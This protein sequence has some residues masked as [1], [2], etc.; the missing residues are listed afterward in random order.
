MKKKS[1]FPSPP[2]VLTLFFIA[3]FVPAC[4]LTLRQSTA[5]PSAASLTDPQPLTCVV[6]DPGHG[7]EDGGAVSASGLSEKEVNLAVALFLRD[8]LELNGI[9]VVM[10]REEDVLLYDPTADHQGRKKVLD[11]LSRKTIGA[12]CAN[13]LLVSIHMN[14]F[15]QPQY[16]GTQVW[17]GQKDPRSQE[18]AHSIQQSAL[19]L[20]PDNHR[21]IKTAGSGIYLLDQLTTPCVLVECGF[22]SNPEEAERLED[23][24]YQKALA[25]MIFG[26]IAPYLT[27]RTVP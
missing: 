22:L 18:I 17:Y 9:P 5:L 12:H 16:S 19:L 15:A 3:L 25:W 26:G 23:P 20:Q 27:P 11:L 4:L 7:G 14:A 2:L 8:I 1:S 10:T 24:A 13:G 21:R 6:I